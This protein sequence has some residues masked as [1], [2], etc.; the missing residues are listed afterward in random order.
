LLYNRDITVRYF[1]TLFKTAESEFESPQLSYLPLCRYL[2]VYTFD[3]LFNS[4]ISNIASREKRG[5]TT[6]NNE[7]ERIVAYF[8]T[9]KFAL[10]DKKYG[11]LLYENRCRSRD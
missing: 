3:G 6:V 8:N 11:G 9:R 4:G 5:W 1:K 7:K 10:S 2:I